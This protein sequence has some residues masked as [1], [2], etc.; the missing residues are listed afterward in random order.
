MDI[1]TQ[2][3]ESVLDGIK[4]EDLANAIDYGW[5][6]KYIRPDYCSKHWKLIRD[7]IEQRGLDTPILISQREDGSLHVLQGVLR[8][9]AIL[10]MYPEDKHIHFPNGL[11][12]CR[13]VEGLTEE[14]ERYLACDHD[15]P[16]AEG[17]VPKTNMYK[18]SGNSN[19]DSDHLE[20]YQ[21]GQCSGY[22][23]VS[24]GGDPWAYCPA[25]GRKVSEWVTE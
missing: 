21:C 12:P 19:N 11:V 22:M 25:C 23:C 6:R 10:N 14:Q 2:M 5:Y 13:Y 15:I 9:V 24:I 8:S 1:E 7:S 17:K 16:L 18:V 4:C 3:Y 20:E